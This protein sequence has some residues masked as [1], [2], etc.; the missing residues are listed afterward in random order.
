MDPG[1]S[2]DLSSRS[3]RVEDLSLSLVFRDDG[4][5]LKQQ[6]REGNLLTTLARAG[7][8]SAS[9]CALE[10]LFLPKTEDVRDVPVGNGLDD[11]DAMLAYSELPIQPP[12]AE[13][14]SIFR[15]L[16]WKADP[17]LQ[18]YT[19]ILAGSKEEADI[20]EIL[21]ALR[22]LPSDMR[23]APILASSSINDKRLMEQLARVAMSCSEDDAGATG[24][25]R[26]FVDS[27]DRWLRRKQ[28]GV[29]ELRILLKSFEKAEDGLMTTEILMN[30]LASR[31]WRYLPHPELVRTD[32]PY[33]LE[34]HY[35]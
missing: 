31:Y 30:Y 4:W 26:A 29:A 21:F 7:S 33:E 24:E 2:V 27:F 13:Q 5:E 1:P 23:D 28:L 32:D 19:I 3:W 15:K 20:Q 17:T 18:V 11:Y 25:M 35:E 9:Q 10:L 22:N 6:T 16:D 8:L 12:P 14:L 34:L